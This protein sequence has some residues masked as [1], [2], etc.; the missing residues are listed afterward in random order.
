MYFSVNKQTG[1][2]LGVNHKNFKIVRYD[3]IRPEQKK[4][5]YI[6]FLSRQ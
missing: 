5:K 3:Q 4:K 6:S 2:T 1:I